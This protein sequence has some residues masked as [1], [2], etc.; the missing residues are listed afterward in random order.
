MARRR[1]G[2]EEQPPGG[3][4]AHHDQR[5][6][7]RAGHER[8]RTP[9]GS[10]VAVMAMITIGSSTPP[11]TPAAERSTS[12]RRRS[13]VSSRAVRCRCSA[14]GIELEVVAVGQHRQLGQHLH[15]RGDQ[16]QHRER[17]GRQGQGLAQLGRPVGH[18]GRGHRHQQEGS[19]TDGA[20]EQEERAAARPAA[21]SAARSRRRSGPST[22][23]PTRPV[24]ATAIGQA[25]PPR[26]GRRRSR[27]PGRRPR[28]A[29]RTGRTPRSPGSATS[30]A[31]RSPPA[32]RRAGGR[33]AACC[34]AE[35]H[36]ARAARASPEVHDRP[37]SRRSPNSQR[38]HERA[39]RQLGEHQHHRQRGVGVGR[40]ERE[41]VGG[42]HRRRQRSARAVAGARHGD[43]RRRRGRAPAWPVRRAPAAVAGTGLDDQLGGAHHRDADGLGRAPLHA[44]RRLALGQAVPAHVALADDARGRGRRPAPRRGTSAC[45][46]CSRCTGRRGAQTMPVTGSLS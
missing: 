15:H 17:A 22:P 28:P 4:L 21:T 43:R 40:L 39:D 2:Q 6:R 37:T 18:G 12:V 11:S 19:A 26:V 35:R 13:P 34:A 5:Q 45:S 23:T 33:G 3:E 32:T 31:R 25:P 41:L 36:A 1:H 14:A 8:R 9:D 16:H 27:S 7:R 20:G 10:G 42:H 24:T 30:G 29:R 38:H 46:S 44:R